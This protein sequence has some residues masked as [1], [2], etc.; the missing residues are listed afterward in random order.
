MRFASFSFRLLLLVLFVAIGLALYEW[1]RG[2][3]QDMPWTPLSLGDQVG[4]FTPL[5]LSRLRDDSARCRALLDEAGQS[6][7]IA[8]PVAAGASCGYRDGISLKQSAGYAYVP[9]ATVACGMAA[10]LFL[11][12][13]QIVNPAARKYFGSAVV[14][15]DT[16]GSYSCRRIRGTGDGGWSEHATANAIDIAGF[17]LAD[18]RRLTVAADWSGNDPEARFLREVRDGGCRIFG[19]TLSPDYNAAHRD[20]LHLDLARRAG[21]AFC[22]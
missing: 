18:G 3:P 13:H 2:H 9:H 14:R 4:R 5:K 15:V 20:H 17:R 16:F 10:A 1:G 19:T 11:W 7:H 22:R 8:S 6:Y 12:E 21:W